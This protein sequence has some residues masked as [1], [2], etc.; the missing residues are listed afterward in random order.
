VKII[1]SAVF[2]QPTTPQ[3]E[4][5]PVYVEDRYYLTNLRW[6]RFDAAAILSVLTD[7]AMEKMA[8][9]T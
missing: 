4:S 8:A 9:E 7:R 5:V 1:S 2:H 3:P 6:D